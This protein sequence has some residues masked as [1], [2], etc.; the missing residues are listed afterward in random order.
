MDNSIAGFNWQLETSAVPGP[1]CNEHDEA[2]RKGQRLVLFANNNLERVS[3]S[4]GAANQHVKLD[5][6]TTSHYRRD[7]LERDAIT[8]E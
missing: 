4:H 5:K 1:F 8:N 2:T 7:M 6:L 3:S